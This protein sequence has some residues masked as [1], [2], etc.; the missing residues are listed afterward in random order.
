M[1]GWTMG[2]SGAMWLESHRMRKVVTPPP[3][4]LL[5]SWGPP[6][7][8]EPLPPLGPP[9]PAA[10][11]ASAAA[12][13]CRRPGHATPTARWRATGRDTDKCNCND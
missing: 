2:S 5:A 8:A 4:V 12:S 11:A 7:P 1:F 13:S 6:G 3:P 10:A 9:E